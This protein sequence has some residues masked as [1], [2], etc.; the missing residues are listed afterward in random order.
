MRKEVLFAILCGA[1]LGILGAFGIWKVAG[2]LRQAPP[3]QDAITQTQSPSPV[4]SSESSQTP[5]PNGFSITLAKPEANAVVS[6]SPLA[7]SGVTHADSILTFVGSSTEVVLRA[8]KSGV[9]ETTFPLLGGLNF[10]QIT[11]FS[12]GKTT[13]VTLP[14]VYSSEFNLG[15][16]EPTAQTASDSS[17][18][19]DKVQ[20]K[21]ATVSKKATSYRGTITDL[22][23]G[24]IQLKDPQGQ[25]LQVSLLS[26]VTSFVKQTATSSSTLKSTDLAIGDYILALGT[27]DANSVLSARRII[28]TTSPSYTDPVVYLGKLTQISDKSLS[29]DTGNGIQTVTLAKSVKLT[30][31][32]GDK[33]LTTKSLTVGSRVLVV[34]NRHVFALTD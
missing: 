27:R 32:S 24:T 6:S 11:A 9:F 22:T 21:L 2:S 8:S 28:V 20:E 4:L 30:N 16:P 25:I 13:G 29:V 31:E 17:A 5:D 1:F 3:R 12:S 15:S 19:R 26:D 18:I 33:T 7:I 14:I 10:I 34:E 23:D